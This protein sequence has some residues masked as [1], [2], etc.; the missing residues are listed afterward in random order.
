M[1][2]LSNSPT[3]SDSIPMSVVRQRRIAAMY[4]AAI[5]RLDAT[6]PADVRSHAR[7]CRWC[8]VLYRALIQA[9]LA[10]GQ[11]GPPLSPHVAW[12]RH[13]RRAA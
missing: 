3:T 12:F 11:L 6:N 9:D 10:V 1:H 8:D 4:A 7:A 5:A 2:S 13:D